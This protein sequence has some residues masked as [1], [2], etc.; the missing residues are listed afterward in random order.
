MKSAAIRKLD[1]PIG[2]L[3]VAHPS[4]VE[5]VGIVPAGLV[6]YQQKYQQTARI[7]TDPR[8]PPRTGQGDKCQQLL[9]YSA[10]SE[11]PRTIA[12]DEVVPLAGLEPA[13]CCHHLILSQVSEISESFHCFPRLGK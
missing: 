6:R 7:P 4:V 3:G 10:F 8:A 2:A 12:N 11:R 13:R 1:W 9:D 5:H